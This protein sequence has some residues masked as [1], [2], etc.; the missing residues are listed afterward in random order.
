MSASA[1]ANKLKSLFIGLIATWCAVSPF[2]SRAQSKPSKVATWETEADTL[3]S[4][5][6]YPAAIALYDKVVSKTKL[7]T[8][9]DY[10][11]LYK[12]AYALYSVTEFNRALADINQYLARFPDVQGKLLR[13][14]IYQ[15]LGDQEAQRK[16]L[17]ELL[18]ENPGNL[19]LMYLRVSLQMEGGQYRAAQ[20]SLRELMAIQP[21]PELKAYLGLTHYYLEQPDSAL[22]IF[23]EVIAEAPGYTQTYLF[24]ASLCL[25]EEA[26]PLALSYVNRGLAHT[27][28]DATLLFYK[29]NALLEM[30]NLDEGCR[31]L[32]KAFHS[33]FDDA[34]DY[35]KEYC[36]SN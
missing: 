3:M 33:G 10:R 29:G 18:R 6:N 19:D 30:D 32:T 1:T 8:Q 16:E 17:D 4:Q 27:P 11:V 25:E 12:R 22:T 5:M 36:Y 26:Y 35:L 15:E 13:L 34:A 2:F 9:E 31:C 23:D 24:A 7:K 14:Q 21:A 20:Q 28:G